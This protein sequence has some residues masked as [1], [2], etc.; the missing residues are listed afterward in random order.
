MHATLIEPCICNAFIDELKKLSYDEVSKLFFSKQQDTSKIF[1][2]INKEIENVIRH[3][4]CVFEFY[5]QS[6]L[7]GKTSGEHNIRV[8]SWVITYGYHQLLLRD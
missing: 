3:Q 5:R 2:G 1:I 8:I 6:L 4:N 7:M